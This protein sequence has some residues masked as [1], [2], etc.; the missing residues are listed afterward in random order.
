MEPNTIPQTQMAPQVNVMNPTGVDPN[1]AMAQMGE[2]SNRQMQNTIS[3][4]Q[5]A[6]QNR[7]MQQQG[8][9]HKEEMGL[10]REE[11]ARASKE[12]EANRQHDINMQSRRSADD[13]KRAAIESKTQIMLERSKE[14]ARERRATA[15][16]ARRNGSLEEADKFEKEATDIE[17][18]ANDMQD[19]LHLFT[20]LSEGIINNLNAE[21]PNGFVRDML[22]QVNTNIMTMLPNYS[23]AAKDISS[24]LLN[25]GKKSVVGGSRQLYT[26]D[27]LNMFETP[28][29]TTVGQGVME[30]PNNPG[31]YFVVL[32]KYDK[33]GMLDTF[34][35]EGFE[36]LSGKTTGLGKHLEKNPDSGKVEVVTTDDSG[37]EINR[38]PAT[39]NT[40]W[41]GFQIPQWLTNSESTGYAT[42]QQLLE[43][44]YLKQNEVL[45]DLN[46]LGN[47]MT[48]FMKNQ[49]YEFDN[50]S[51]KRLLEDM[52]TWAKTKDQDT[53]DNVKTTI[54]G[55]VKKNKDKEGDS[56]DEKRFRYEIGNFMTLLGAAASGGGK[57]QAQMVEN[58]NMERLSQGQS[59]IEFKTSDSP[60]LQNKTETHDI[61]GGLVDKAADAGLFGEGFRRGTLN[62]NGTMLPNIPEAKLLVS[63]GRE[64][65]GSADNVEFLRDMEKI[66]ENP[67]DDFAHVSPA[68]QKLLASLKP[69]EIKFL[70]D[71]VHSTVTKHI[72]EHHAKLDVFGPNYSGEAAANEL[73]AKRQS[74]EA[75]RRKAGVVGNK[76]AVPEPSTTDIYDD[77]LK[78][79]DT[80]Y[81]ER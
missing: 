56:F 74:V 31:H 69:G 59:P 23:N 53:F 52:Y 19:N 57:V 44:G 20:S 39:D 51:G 81:G 62:L 78:E 46:D 5:T 7:Q 58:L 36:K 3:Q 71:L 29:N 75:L 18:N 2:L 17:N 45:P 35:K 76:N 12:N 61:L 55:L 30:D 15:A 40:S 60:Y 22:N 24:G 8:Q 13:M 27:Q 73:R 37:K 10:R 77:L 48:N 32:P 26:P 70:R 42:K 4:R 49:K 47:A 63:I 1:A 50:S 68:G 65:M 11:M 34:P 80:L 6:L 64:L 16:Q 54:D 66:D 21:N 28:I 14:Q 25:A 43:A 9:Q 79:T 33:N 38:V 72:A 67:M 41:L